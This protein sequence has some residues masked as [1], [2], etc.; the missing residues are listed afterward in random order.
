MVRLDEG[1]MLRRTSSIMVFF[2]LLSGASTQPRSISFFLILDMLMAT[3]CPAKHS[4]ASLPCTCM[5]RI[6]QGLFTGNTARESSLR[7]R[8][9]IRV[10]VTMVPKPD[11]EKTRSMGRRGM[12]SISLGVTSSAVM[13]SMR[14]ISSGR[15]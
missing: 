5:E 8:P 11:M 7:M 14:E 9:E 2:M 15:P 1:S 13:R 4:S 10:P 3:R 12:V 6:L